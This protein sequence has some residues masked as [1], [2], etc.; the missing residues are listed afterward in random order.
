MLFY[1]PIVFLGLLSFAVG[2][3]V[4]F[5]GGLQHSHF[6]GCSAASCNF[7]VLTGEDECMSYCSSISCSIPIL[8]PPDVKSWLIG[9]DPDAGKDW[10]QKEKGMTE[11]EMVGWH[12]QFNGHGFEQALGV[13]DGQES[14]AFCSPWGHRVGHDWATELICTGFYCV[15]VCHSWHSVCFETVELGYISGFVTAIILPRSEALCNFLL[16]SFPPEVV[17]PIKRSYL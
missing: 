1:P 7:G 15:C 14:L 6:T 11:D 2:H 10:R 9:K 17:L 16:F 8:L 4:S 3:G 5:F 13:G 12:Q